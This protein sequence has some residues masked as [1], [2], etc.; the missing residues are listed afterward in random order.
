M[1]YSCRW[2]QFQLISTIRHAFHSSTSIKQYKLLP[3]KTELDVIVKLSYCSYIVCL[4]NLDDHRRWIMFQCLQSTM[5][6]LNSKSTT[7]YTFLDPSKTLWS[8]YM[9]NSFLIWAMNFAG[10]VWLHNFTG[11]G[12]R[13]E[14]FY[15]FVCNCVFY[16]P[17][18]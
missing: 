3:L 15:Q 7:E 17:P 16:P 6:S 14:A 11:I 4:S 1:A 12:C 8:F 5:N 2:K 9:W 18:P 10:K 13:R